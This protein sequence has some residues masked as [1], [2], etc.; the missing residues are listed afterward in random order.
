MGAA[1]CGS[2]ND[3]GGGRVNHDDYVGHDEKHVTRQNSS[4]KLTISNASQVKNWEAS[5]K[6]D[7][8]CTDLYNEHQSLLAAAGASYVS[9][10]SGFQKGDCLMI[11]DMQN[12]FL[13]KADA[14]DGGAFGVAEGATSVLAID[15]MAR[16]AAKAGAMIIA[17]RDYHPID[18][19]SFF[20]NG[21]PFPPHC[22]QGSKGAQF[23]PPIKEILREI[24]EEGGD[25]KI[26][27]KGWHSQTDSFGAISYGKEFWE[28]R[29]LGP[30]TWDTKCDGCSAVSWTGSYHLKCSNQSNDLDAP[31]DVMAVIARKN[32]ADTFKESSIKRLF[33][34]GLA[35]DFCVLDSALNAATLGRTDGE[36]PL[37]S[38]SQTFMVVDASRA[39]HIPK[40]TEHGG[41]FGTGFLSNPEDLV[42]KCQAAGVQ[43]IRSA[44][45]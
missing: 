43:L 21:G 31:P 19:C 26:V 13:P 6:S 10:K 15:E 16:K 27:F 33:V 41:S 36:T 23:F 4:I 3:Q 17:T 2:G 22:V 32:L 37:A 42:K 20:T 14:P 38:A 44:E 34:C 12:D 39:A 18:H 1:L 8:H 25:V 45:I 11:V 40:N 29:K 30:Q 35:L 9:L 5:V 7:P 28:E 24:Q